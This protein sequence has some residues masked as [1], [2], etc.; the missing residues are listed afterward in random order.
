VKTQ[1]GYKTEINLNNVQRTN[2]D[3]HAG[4]APSAIIR[5]PAKM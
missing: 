4:A 5:A 1:K 3:K 2:C